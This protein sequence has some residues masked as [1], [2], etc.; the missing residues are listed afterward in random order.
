MFSF[1]KTSQKIGERL[2]DALPECCKGFGNSLA[3]ME[4]SGH[5][6]CF[7]AAK[8]LATVRFAWNCR[9]ICS[10]LMQQSIW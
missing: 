7:N 4:L 8:Y 10:A 3:R 9:G 5:M 1:R 2:P 6:L